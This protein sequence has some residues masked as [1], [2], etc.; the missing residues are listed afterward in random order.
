M[1]VGFQGFGRAVDAHF[2]TN[3]CSCLF[4]SARELFC[5]IIR[6]NKKRYLM[7]GEAHVLAID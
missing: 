2:D 3:L 1:Q 4:N 5:G 6:R 7:K